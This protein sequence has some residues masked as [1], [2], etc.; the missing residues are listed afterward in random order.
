MLRLLRLALACC[1]M[2]NLAAA[3]APTDKKEPVAKKGFGLPERKGKDAH[4]LE[5]LK[6][7]WY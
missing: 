3:D 5:L 6:V 4:H 1:L 2:A 7:G